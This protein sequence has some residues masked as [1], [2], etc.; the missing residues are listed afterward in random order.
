MGR[1]ERN[2][3][4]RLSEYSCY[5]HNAD[6]SHFCKFEDHMSP[7]II[8]G[9][10]NFDKLKCPECASSLTHRTLSG[11]D[12]YIIYQDYKGELLFAKVKCIYCQRYMPLVLGNG[13]VF[14]IIS[15][16]RDGK[17]CVYCM[18]CDRRYDYTKSDFEYITV[19]EY[20]DLVET[21]YE[22]LSYI[23]NERIIDE[24][25]EDV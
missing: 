21:E 14:D 8:L 24:L 22:N 7:Q 12:D 3:L 4:L 19:D 6:F 20:D 9:Y 15:K 13:K 17:I 5:T 16:A 1:I 18:R 2:V 25:Q 11:T 23:P 10:K